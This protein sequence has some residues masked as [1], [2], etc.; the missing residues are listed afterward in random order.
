M[1]RCTHA[2]VGTPGLVTEELRHH[3]HRLDSDYTLDSEVRLVSKRAC[4]VVRAELIS[5][6][7]GVR[8]KELRPLVEK[9]E[10]YYNHQCT[11]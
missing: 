5:G 9:L 6:D 7:K 1:Q 3:S 8:N 11:V 10:L 2:V 4:E